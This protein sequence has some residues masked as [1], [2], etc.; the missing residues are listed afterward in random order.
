M[1]DDSQQ[2]LG[3]FGESEDD[4]RSAAEAAAIG[5]PAFKEMRNYLNQARQ[6][7]NRPSEQRPQ[8]PTA[9]LPARDT[10]EHGLVYGSPETVCEKL[11]PLSK[12]GVGGVILRFR[13]GAMSWEATEHSLRLFADKVAPEFGAATVE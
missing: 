4:S 6:R 10:V 7:L 12:I 9:L 5:I 11:E 13:L 2:A 8:D 1:G 3:D